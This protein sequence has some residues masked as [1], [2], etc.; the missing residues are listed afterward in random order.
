[1]TTET[2]RDPQRLTAALRLVLRRYG[3]Q[4]RRQPAI[5]IGALLLPAAGDVLTLYAPPL[6]VAKLLGG[7]VR[8]ERFTV[9]DLTPYVPMFAIL[10]WPD[11]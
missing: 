6:V 1:M 10:W 3:A 4:L 2:D 11:R 9:A 7:F 5:A 8:N